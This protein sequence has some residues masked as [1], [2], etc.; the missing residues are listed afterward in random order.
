MKIKEK[1]MKI[2]NNPFGKDQEVKFPVRF[3]LKVIM[4]TPADHN[5]NINKLEFVLNTLDIAFHNWR[6]K[7]SGKGTYTSYTV[8]VYIISHEKLSNLYSDL[9]SIPEVKMAI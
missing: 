6:Q 7:P 1:N 4:N 9:K 8:N 5:D 3:D 2:Q